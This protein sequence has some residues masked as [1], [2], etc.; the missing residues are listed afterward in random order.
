MWGFGCLKTS[1]LPLACDPTRC[2][3]LPSLFL[4]PQNL[5]LAYI[6]LNLFG[7]QA[8]KFDFTVCLFNAGELFSS[9]FSPT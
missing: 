7:I 8:M 3:H 2:N 4:N 6:D 1:E 5:A 9:I